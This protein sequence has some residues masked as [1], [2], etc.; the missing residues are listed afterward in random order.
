MTFLSA[1]G[2]SVDRVKDDKSE[3]ILLQDVNC[4]QM[5]VTVANILWESK[6]IC[7]QLVTNIVN[8]TLDAHRESERMIDGHDMV[9]LFVSMSCYVHRAIKETQVYKA[10]QGHVVSLV[11]EVPLACQVSL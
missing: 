1:A 5:F 10:P 7:G 2:E 3:K 11:H 4:L 6:V 9:E 8:L